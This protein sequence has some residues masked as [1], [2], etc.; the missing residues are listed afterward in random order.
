MDFT[1]FKQHC[2]VA[3]ARMGFDNWEIYFAKSKEFMVRVRDGKI[4]EYKN[5]YTQGLSF[6]GKIDGRMGYAYTENPDENIIDT[7]LLKAI[8][9]AKIINSEDEEFLFRGAK[10]Y[11][12]A[13]IYFPEI[14][15]ITVPQKIQ[16]A[17]DMEQA[18]FAAD[19]RVK[20]V[21]Y[22]GVANEEEELY[23][24]NSYG[25]DVNSK[26]NLFDAFIDVIVEENGVTKTGYKVFIGSDINKCDPKKI[27]EK[28]VEMAVT[29][30]AA[31]T[32]PSETLPV[33]F[34][35][36]TAGDILGVFAYGFTAENAQK[37]FSLLK[38]KEGQ[39]IASEI[40]TIHDDGIHLSSFANN[41]FD[42]EG[43]PCRNKVVVDKGVLTT[44]LYNLK[45]SAKEGKESTGNGF[46]HSFRG[47][48]DTSITNFYI[49]PT[50]TSP[51]SIIAGIKRGVLVTQLAGLH[52]GANPI[53]GD[54]SLS[55]SGFLIENGQ[56]IRPV[57]QITVAG[58]FYELL[59][60]I[61]AVGSDLHFDVPR[62]SGCVGCPS[63]LV[64]SLNIAGE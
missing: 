58:N 3:A 46:K 44:L 20:A 49:K 13:Q 1:L 25:L 64:K 33:M 50:D 30:L 39:Q 9:N 40:V 21:S 42:S 2:F 19:P 4:L 36:Y 45:S 22:C 6:R 55:V 47:T 24:S 34:D 48:V 8:E 54:F 17:L 18:A 5:A 60:N 32:I 51:E 56:K 59:N 7:M 38:G 61:T 16:L 29:F 14:N 31:R 15:E 35:K 10:D 62:G 26:R 12:R 27:A 53:T 41:L 28:A 63:I 11:P 43:V 23:I 57:E 37:G 52:S